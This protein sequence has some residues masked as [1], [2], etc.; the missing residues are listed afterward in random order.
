MNLVEGEGGRIIFQYRRKPHW[1]EKSPNQIQNRIMRYPFVTL[2]PDKS[3]FRQSLHDLSC[4][5]EIKQHE[6][7]SYRHHNWSSPSHWRHF[8]F[9]FSKPYKD[10]VIYSDTANSKQDLLENC[11]VETCQ[12]TL[13]LVIFL[14]EILHMNKDYFLKWRLGINTGSVLRGKQNKTKPKQKESE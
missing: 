12:I 11:R 5:T 4:W 13:I 7:S 6:N 14:T 10:N 8:C 2:I 3:I 1:L 9:L